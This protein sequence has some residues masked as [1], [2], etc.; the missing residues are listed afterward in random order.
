M[1]YEY[2]ANEMSKSKKPV[3]LIVTQELDG[4]IKATEKGVRIEQKML[5]DAFQLEKKLN[6]KKMKDNMDINAGTII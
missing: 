5:Q 6:D 3:E 1:D 2:V 4:T